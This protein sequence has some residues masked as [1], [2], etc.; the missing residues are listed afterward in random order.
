MNW[1][2]LISTNIITHLGLHN[3][4]EAQRLKLLAEIADLLQKQIMVRLIEFLNDEEIREFFHLLENNEDKELSKFLDE[5][6]PHL[7]E[8]IYQEVGNLKQDMAAILS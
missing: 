6:V 8:I 5:K 4:D 7:E 2:E 1:R 3:I